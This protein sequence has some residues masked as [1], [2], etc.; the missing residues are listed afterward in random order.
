MI[1]V[2]RGILRTVSVANTVMNDYYGGI[3]VQRMN[4]SWMNQKVQIQQQQQQQQPKEKEETERNPYLPYRHVMEQ[5][6][7]WE[8]TTMV[9]LQTNSKTDNSNSTNNNNNT[10]RR[11][12]RR[13]LNF[14]HI[15]KTG[16]TSIVM[17]AAD[18]N[19]AWGDC[20]FWS[21]R[22]RKNCPDRPINYFTN[23]NNNSTT[24]MTDL[25]H[26]EQY[27]QLHPMLSSW[28]HLPIQFIP[29]D[30]KHINPYQHQDLFV[31]IRNPYQRVVSQYYY[32]C[33]RDKNTPCYLGKK[34]GNTN[35]TYINR[36]TPQQMN[37]VIQQMIR[38][39]QGATIGSK[40]YFYHDGHW[41]P[42]AHYVYSVTTNSNNNNNN[43]N[44]K[45]NNN[46][47]NKQR[48]SSFQFQ[49]LVQHILHFE[50]LQDEFD[51]LMGAY[52]W[53]ITLPK[54]KMLD[55]SEFTTACSVQ[56]LTRTTLQLIEDVYRDD[57]QLGGYPM[58]SSSRKN[59]TLPAGNN[60]NNTKRN[61]MK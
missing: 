59:R 12:R 5:P 11:R 41:I 14:L 58:L 31:V 17:A 22:D 50:Y 15:P 54:H 32:R 18:S 29:N 20:L 25:Y 52:R 26:P 9:I 53:N 19:V 2:V 30:K 55:R 6:K 23:N 48:P 4:S 44:N 3:L 13:P 28:W 21:R 45:S 40:D 1:V 24:N 38:K 51:S 56:N 42:Q 33:W 57:F 49:R 46:S 61:Q 10:K 60:K 35:N 36:D 47:N 27:I 43:N 8:T 7:S 34:D 37:T 16:G 39:Q